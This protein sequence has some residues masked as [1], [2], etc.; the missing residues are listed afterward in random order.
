MFEAM[1][2]PAAP[3]QMAVCDRVKTLHRPPT[4]NETAIVAI[5]KN[6]QGS[7]AKCKMG[8]ICQ[9]VADIRSVNSADTT[10]I[11]NQ[12]TINIR[13]LEFLRINR[14]KRKRKIIRNNK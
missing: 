5:N 13:E 11:S 14:L 6:L 8:I 1:I 4:K 3:R 10:A 12:Y 7:E 2:N 9:I